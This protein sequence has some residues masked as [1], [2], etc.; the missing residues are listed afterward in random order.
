MKITEQYPT[1][2]VAEPVEDGKIILT[3]I[4]NRQQANFL[5]NTAIRGRWMSGSYKALV[6]NMEDKLSKALGHTD[7]LEHND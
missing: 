2:L 4:L 7:G 1:P 5:R 6:T 3:V